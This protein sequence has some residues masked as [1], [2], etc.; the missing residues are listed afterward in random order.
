M[1]R[2]SATMANR[3]SVFSPMDS[4]FRGTQTGST[5]KFYGMEAMIDR[6]PSEWL[7]IVQRENPRWPLAAI[8][9]FLKAIT[10]EHLELRC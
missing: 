7:E 5:F 9:E 6:N 1:S 10:F 8:F 4:R 2:I 3:E